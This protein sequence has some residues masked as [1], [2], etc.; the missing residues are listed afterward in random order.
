LLIRSLIVA[1]ALFAAF[2]L[3]SVLGAPSRSVARPALS[4]A[5]VHPKPARPGVIPNA[6]P[7]R[8]STSQLATAAGRCAAW[9]AKAGFPNTSLG[10]GRLTT[11]VAVALAETGC[12][13]AA[14]YNNSTRRACT[15]PATQPATQ[16]TTQPTSRPTSRPTTR[17][18]RR[19]TTQPTARASTP[20][21][22]QHGGDSFFRGAWQVGGQSRTGVSDTCAYQ[23]RCNGQAA[24][25]VVAGYGTDLRPWTA[26]LTGHYQ[27]YLAAAARAV[28]VLRQGALPSAVTGL[29]A[30]YVTDRPGAWTWL[31]RCGLGSPNEEWT[32]SG[33]QLRTSSG[34]CLTADAASTGGNASTAGTARP[35]PVSVASCTGSSFQ[36]WRPGTKFALTN[37]G[38][39][40][41]LTAPGSP[42][43][44]G[45][46]LTVQPCA[47]RR[48]QRWFRP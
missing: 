20:A 27:R 40:L 6:L 34:L 11:A 14:C 5:I 46:T 21:G 17:P 1:V 32:L 36:D 41:C 24:Y 12:D 30:E 7:V 43:P 31:A 15:E 39:R 35:G 3:V 19:P 10:H 33:Q 16:P 13:P 26:Y 4:P 44:P 29:C 2:F 25:R 23:G 47:G 48:G 8:L 42:A 28:S 37:V 38:A 9:A 18:T 45:T 22:R